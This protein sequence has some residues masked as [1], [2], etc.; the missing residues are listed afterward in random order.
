MDPDSNLAEQLEIAQDI[1][2]DADKGRAISEDDAVRLAELV[3]G[4]DDWLRGRGFLPKR[5]SRGR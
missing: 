5:W 1:L 4:L 3:E 2:K